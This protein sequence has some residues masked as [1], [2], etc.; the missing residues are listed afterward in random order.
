MPTEEPK[1]PAQPTPPKKMAA[2]SVIANPLAQQK[3]KVLLFQSGDQSFGL[4]VSARNIAPDAARDAIGPKDRNDVARPLAQPGQLVSMVLL[5]NI[6]VYG[7][8]GESS[9]DLQVEIL[10]PVQAPLTPKPVTG[11]LAGCS[12]PNGEEGWLYMIVYV[13]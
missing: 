13:S 7:I 1:K 4:R 5:D 8:T 3:D 6:S 12:R 11:A 10:S 2:I 9:D